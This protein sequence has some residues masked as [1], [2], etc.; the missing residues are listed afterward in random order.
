MDAEAYADMLPWLVFIVVDRKTGL[1]V[2]WAAGSAAVCSLALLAWS[3]W[4]GSRASL[5]RIG[6]AV[7]SVCLIVAFAVPAWNTAVSLPRAVMVGT[8]SLAA[9]VSLLAT[10]LSEGYTMPLVAPQARLD[11]RFRKVNVEIT[12]AW[13]VGTAL[14]AVACGTTALLADTYAFTFFGWVAPLALTGGT[15]LWTARRWE[16]FRLAVD[17]H[18]AAASG[19]HVISLAGHDHEHTVK[20]EQPVEGSSGA[21]IRPFPLRRQRDA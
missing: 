3:Y 13:A 19:R 6:L 4:K 8:L 2:T 11:P 5:P 9:L 1:T 14:V 16:L 17:A 7:F 12:A 18:A 10:P 20:A 15:V 21:V